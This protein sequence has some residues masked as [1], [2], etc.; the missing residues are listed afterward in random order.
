MRGSAFGITRVTREGEGGR[1]DRHMMHPRELPDLLDIPSVE[2]G[3]VVDLEAIVDLGRTPSGY[4][5]EEPV[6]VLQIL[7][8]RP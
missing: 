8:H 5:V 4:R 7:P 2:F 1:E 3:T 6:R